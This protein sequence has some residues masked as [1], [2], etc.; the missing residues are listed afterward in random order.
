M[1]KERW[2]YLQK[3]DA[4]HKLLSLEGFTDSE[5]NVIDFIVDEAVD[6]AET[7]VHAVMVDHYSTWKNWE[8]G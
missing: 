7:V 6:V 8:S 2:R 3:L 4:N 5:G 1:W